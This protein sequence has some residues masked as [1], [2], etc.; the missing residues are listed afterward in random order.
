MKLIITILLLINGSILLGQANPAVYLETDSSSVIFNDTDL[1]DRQD[2]TISFWFKPLKPGNIVGANPTN[3]ALDELNRTEMDDF[4]RVEL[5]PNGDITFHFLNDFIEN[6]GRKSITLQSNIKFG[7]WNHLSISQDFRKLFVSGNLSNPQS[8]II[9]FSYNRPQ[10]LIF[11]NLPKG[12]IV[13][14]IRTSNHHGFK[15]QIDQVNIY[16]ISLHGTYSESDVLYLNNL[17]YSMFDNDL[18]FTSPPDPYG[19]RLIKETFEGQATNYESV[20]SEIIDSDCFE[21]NEL[22]RYYG[23]LEL[24]TYGNPKSKKR[25]RYFSL[26][27]AFSKSSFA[28]I[29]NPTD[30][31]RGYTK[32]DDGNIYHLSI[33][34]MTIWSENIQSIDITLTLNDIED[35]FTDDNNTINPRKFAIFLLDDNDEIEKV[36]ITNYNTNDGSLQAAIPLARHKQK[37]LLGDLYNNFTLSSDNGFG[38]FKAT[39]TKTNNYTVSDA[40]Y[41]D[42]VNIKTYDYINQETIDS[43]YFDNT[44]SDETYSHNI[45]DLSLKSSIIVNANTSE[46]PGIGFEIEKAISI[47]PLK[48]H[49]TSARNFQPYRIGTKNIKDTITIDSISNNTNKLV[50]ELVDYHGNRLDN[51]QETIKTL[52]GTELT[53]A[54]WVLDLENLPL[55]LGSQLKITVFQE[56]GLING[57]EELLSL[58]IQPPEMYIGS[59]RNTWEFFSNNFERVDNPSDQWPEF[60]DRFAHRF[61]VFDLPPRT[62]KVFISLASND[63]TVYNDTILPQYHQSEI[64]DAVFSIQMDTIPT[65][66]SIMEAIVMADGGPTDGLE[67]FHQIEVI[68]NSPRISLNPINFDRRPNNPIDTNQKKITPVTISIEPSF[69]NCETVELKILTYN[70]RIVKDTILQV[71]SDR[72]YPIAETIIDFANINPFTRFIHAQA[73]DPNGVFLSDTL[74]TVELKTPYPLLESLLPFDAKYEVNIPD[75]IS[76]TNGQ[77]IYEI[78]KFEGMPENTNK[79]DI[80]FNLENYKRYILQFSD[81]DQQFAITK[82]TDKINFTE[83][84]EI[85]GYSISAKFKTSKKD[86]SIVSYQTTNDINSPD[87]VSKFIYLKDGKLNF[88]NINKDGGNPFII[89]SENTFNDNEWHHVVVSYESNFTGGEAQS[90]KYQLYVDGNKEAE[91]VSDN[92]SSSQ[93]VTEDF[94]GYWIFGN[95]GQFQ[96]NPISVDRSFIGNLGEVAVS[97][98]PLGESEINNLF[99]F[100]LSENIYNNPF[101]L[102]HYWDFKGTGLDY[103]ENLDLTYGGQCK[104]FLDPTYLYDISDLTQRSFTSAN[105]LTNRSLELYGDS[106]S[107]YSRSG[108][109]T[110][111]FLGFGNF[112]F[113]GWFK[114]KS[115]LNQSFVSFNQQIDGPEEEQDY[116]KFAQVNLNSAGNIVFQVNNE[117]IQTIQSFNNNVWTHFTCTVEGGR[118]MNIFINGTLVKTL[119]LDNES[120]NLSEVQEYNINIGYNETLDN[121]LS[122]DGEISAFSF[123]SKALDYNDIIKTMHDSDFIINSESVLSYLEFSEDNYYEQDLNGFLYLNLYNKSLSS[124]LSDFGIF[125]GSG[126]I[127]KSNFLFNQNNFLSS[128]VLPLNMGR[129]SEGNYEMSLNIY[130]TDKTEPTLF[131]WILNVESNGTDIP[132]FMKSNGGFGFFTEGNEDQIELEFF[133]EQFNGAENTKLTIYDRNPNEP[134]KQILETI[135]PSFTPGSKVQIPFKTASAK[136][137]S[138]VEC[139]FTY[140]NQPY[141]FYFPL[142]ARPGIPPKLNGDFSNIFEAIAPN[143]MSDVRKF[144]IG[145]QEDAVSKFVVRAVNIANQALGDT[146]TIPINSTNTKQSFFTYDVSK[147]KSPHS[148]LILE[149]YF[150]DNPI[151]DT[152]ISYPI[153]V[154]RTRPDWFNSNMSYSNITINDENI[155]FEL[156]GFL[157]KPEVTSYIAA[158]DSKIFDPF[159]VKPIPASYYLN[160]DAIRSYDLPSALPVLGGK[161]ISLPFSKLKI[162]LNYDTKTRKLSIL[163]KPTISYQDNV[164]GVNVS[165]KVFTIDNYSNLLDNKNNI[166]FSHFNSYSVQ[167]NLLGPGII[168]TLNKV[169]EILKEERRLQIADLFQINIDINLAYALSKGQ[170]LNVRSDANSWGNIGKLDAGSFNQ[171][172]PDENNTDIASFAYSQLGLG[173]AIGIDANL[174]SGLADAHVSV[175]IRFLFGNISMNHDLPY[176]SYRKYSSVSNQIFAKATASFC[177]GLVKK[178]IFGPELIHTFHLTDNQIPTIIPTPVGW[179]SGLGAKPKGYKLQEGEQSGQASFSYDSPTSPQPELDSDNDNLVACWLEQDI[180]TKSAKLMISYFEK[181]SNK[182]LNSTVISENSSGMSNPKVSINNNKVYVTWMQNRHNTTN[183]PDNVSLEYLFN[184]TDIWFAVYDLGTKELLHI[185]PIEDDFE[186]FDKGRVEGRPYVAA[187]SDNQAMLSWFVANSETGTSDVYYATIDFD[188]TNFTHSNPEIIYETEGTETDLNLLRTSD[189][190]CLVTWKSSSDFG[191]SQQLLSS[192]WDGSAWSSPNIFLESDESFMINDVDSDIFNGKGLLAVSVHDMNDKDADQILVYHWNESQRIWES[193]SLVH[194]LEDSYPRDIRV[195]VSDSL[196][197]VM[198]E[199]HKTNILDDSHLGENDILSVDINDPIELTHLN[200]NEYFSEEPTK[201]W[202]YD[203]D[204]INNNT[205]FL[206]SNEIMNQGNTFDPINGEIFSEPSN[207][208]IF[209]AFKITNDFEI[210][211][212]DE[213]NI[214]SSLIEKEELSANNIQVYPQPATNFVMV[215]GK[216]NRT[217]KIKR[218]YNSAGLTIA[219]YDIDFK[220]TYKLNLDFPSGLYFIEVQNDNS[221]TRIPII[222]MEHE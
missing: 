28:L 38:P 88:Y 20:Y 66:T 58:N 193:N 133:S 40:N 202:H 211:D 136:A 188:G 156:E 152:S 100:N 26:D 65:G 106:V 92:G 153:N 197:V 183:V 67:V 207:N 212:V 162:K 160:S 79:V 169:R 171:E 155:S 196:A 215:N 190:Q 42:N 151:P 63:G 213:D 12:N 52:T 134:N 43:V 173:L 2:W 29:T 49:V 222:I 84:D 120:I 22:D 13:D 19:T 18:F 110:A 164:F 54:E 62:R 74:I 97:K 218:L 109:E 180:K 177:W 147:L 94:V 113:T 176:P 144:S 107:I 51:S 189:D 10:K 8:T 111:N 117:S 214:I 45:S 165:E 178:T 201:T 131:N 39:Y 89:S 27:Q 5:E 23:Y 16:P 132:L 170:F 114:T 220:G 205:F 95:S 124:E 115:D 209:R 90:T 140:L 91:L 4:W 194:K 77:N 154:N 73:L 35:T 25:F 80:D 121:S 112:S 116:S 59:E 168:G 138:W 172:N 41:F 216:L 150:D 125:Y 206:L 175:T 68:P 24:L 141:S 93:N 60:E 98:T 31:P 122:I 126:F 143:T 210:E 44:S 3:G 199:E 195:T 32:V 139:Q 142:L 46:N 14:G 103:I 161:G 86:G 145:N 128:L 78:F 130:E 47:Y 104:W 179:P 7:V 83:N 75:T 185:S 149:S 1:L 167:G 158:T 217:N 9:E 119:A 36:I 50:L 53:N 82:N 34:T 123:W 37:I 208:L 159:A 64:T 204:I 174:L 99:S 96:A 192:Y 76:Y 200:S 166:N 118:T 137:G 186:T 181:E 198:F 221:I 127:S 6:L 146:I 135:S 105:E 81:A 21:V 72:G 157:D 33:D 48:I 70:N 57:E 187:L 184:T 15:G 191:N 102:N 17:T 87:Q 129:L 182:F 101:Y 71:N 163:D 11:G 56:N 61:R 85:S 55:V 69:S 30:A 148:Y 108:S 219:N 203:L